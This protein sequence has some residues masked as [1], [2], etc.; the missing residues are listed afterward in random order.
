[1]RIERE[2]AEYERRMQ[3]IKEDYNRDMARRQADLDQER[4]NLYDE[5]EKR[6]MRHGGPWLKKW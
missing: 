1:M 4:A 5:Q 6:R 2:R 3:A